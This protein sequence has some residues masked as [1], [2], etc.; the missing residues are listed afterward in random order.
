MIKSVGGEEFDVAKRAV[1]ATKL[2]DGDALVAVHLITAED[3]VCFISKKGFF[4][5][6]NIADIPVKKKAAIGVRGMKLSGDDV[7]VSAVFMAPGESVSYEHKGADIAL[8]RLRI[9]TRD[10]KG[11]KK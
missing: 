10:T 9:A 2:S 7:L 6:I 8:D 1:A 4:L 11:V 3:T 5:R